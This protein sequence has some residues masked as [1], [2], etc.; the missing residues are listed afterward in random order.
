M[1]KTEVEDFDRQKVLEIYGVEPTGMIEVKG[2]MGD[3]SDNI[4]GVPGVGE[5]TALGL[6]KEYIDID[7]TD[8]IKSKAE[9]IMKTGVKMKD[10]YHVAC[11]VYSLC[12][13]FLTTDDRL[14]RYQTSQIQM[15]NPID[16][17]RRL[18]GDVN[19]Q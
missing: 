9:E 15:L 10:A 5:K 4:P 16:F 7:K 14:L 8:I 2:L 17:I 13:C 18:E 3:T 12:D 11:A 19:G 6:I 1:G